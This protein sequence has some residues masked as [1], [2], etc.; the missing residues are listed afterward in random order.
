MYELVEGQQAVG[1]QMV[2]SIR[3]A[4]PEDAEPIIALDDVAQRDSR[5]REF[6]QGATDNGTCFVAVLDGQCV[7]YGVLE[8][9]FYGYGFVPMLV[10]GPTHRRLGIGTSLM[11]HVES[12]CQTSKLF[13]STNASNEAMRS[14]L[15]KL[16]YERSG[17]IYNLDPDDPELVYLRN[18]R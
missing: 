10:V 1:N 14:L 13:T 12:I 9:T 6:I 17:V 18:I 7:G 8:Y 2:A 15:A 4:H 16:G 3:L 5:R 11:R